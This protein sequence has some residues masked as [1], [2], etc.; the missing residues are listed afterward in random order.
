V[1]VPIVRRHTFN[2]P[3]H[4]RLEPPAGTTAGG[5]AVLKPR[6]A[7]AQSSSVRDNG[8]AGGPRQVSVE[9][10]PWQAPLRNAAVPSRK[11]SG[12]VDRLKERRAK[13]SRTPARDA[14]ERELPPVA[15][16]D[17][18]S[19]VGPVVE[20]APEVPQPVIPE[21]AEMVTVPATS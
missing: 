18:E 15:E 16:P 21:A 11:F 5:A 10:K 8:F 2:V 12:V 14:P 7:P 20:Q 13:A 4:M 19:D 17:F 6:V 3:R 9:L 1:I